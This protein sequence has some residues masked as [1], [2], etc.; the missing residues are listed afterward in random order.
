MTTAGTEDRLEADPALRHEPL[1][2]TP[3]RHALGGHHRGTS[4]RRRTLPIVG[5]AVGVVV[6][7]ALIVIAPWDSARQQFFADEYTVLTEPSSA[8]V[9]SLAAATGMNETGRRIFLA[10]TPEIENATAFNADCSV[11]TE[12]TLGCFDGT[13]IFIYRVTDTRLTG[14]M[15]V[16][17]AHEMLHA[18][19]QRMSEAER[20]E[21]DKLVASYVATLPSDDKTF[22]TLQDGYAEADFADEWH[23]RLGTEY[24]KL[25][26][27]LEAHYAHYFDSRAKVL[28]LFQRSVAVLDAFEAKLAALA[29]DL[30]AMDAALTARQSAFTAAS[31]QLDVDISAFNARADSGGFTSETEF[32]TARQVLV[33]RQAALQTELTSLNSDVEIYNGKVAELVALD[34]DY[35]EL[36]TKLDSTSAPDTTQL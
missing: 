28:S 12:G 21:V 32:R 6:I 31:A 34:S 19:Y 11:E 5:V 33:D 7:A 13:D 20:H 22:A 9:V 18:A 1:P 30:D 27:K 10:S 36:Y 17:A 3:P 14:T 16:T 26:K 24:S 25:P 2:D 29:S 23:S 35:A 15:E 4:T 8:A